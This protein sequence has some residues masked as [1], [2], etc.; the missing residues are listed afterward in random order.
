[1]DVDVEARS[2]ARVWSHEI[3]KRS[4]GERRSRDLVFRDVA[5]LEAAWLNK[6]VD[7]A[8]IVADEY[9]TLRSRV[10]MEPVFVTVDDGGV[11][12][13]VVLLVRRDGRVRKVLD[14]KG[15]RL[16]A[17]VEHANS[18]HLKWLEVLLMGEGFRTAAD[19]FSKIGK[20]KGPSQAILSVFFGQSDACLTTLQAFQLASELNPQVGSELFPV[21]RSPGGA[22]GVI[23]FRPDLSEADKRKLTDVLERMHLD[24]QGRQLLRLFRMSALVPFKSEYLDSVD[25]LQKEHDRLVR[26]LARGEP[27]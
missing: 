13:S 12:Q 9:V 18:V 27:R 10:S 22:S 16:S 26:L 5:S 19:F 8:A 4:F 6:E 15:G 3:L 11:Y 7:V 14:L 2:V 20:A 1:V 24:P 21:A 25:A 23:V 17:S